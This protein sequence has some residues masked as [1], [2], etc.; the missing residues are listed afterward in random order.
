MNKVMGIS[1]LCLT[2][3]AL[4]AAKGL[5]VFLLGAAPGA[6]GFREEHHAVHPVSRDRDEIFRLTQFARCAG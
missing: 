4:A 5:R 6:A 1:A 2:L 3:C